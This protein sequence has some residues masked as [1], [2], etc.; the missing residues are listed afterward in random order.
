MAILDMPNQVGWMWWLPGALAL[1]QYKAARLAHDFVAVAFHDFGT[2]VHEQLSCVQT[3]ELHLRSADR[4][5][6][7]WH[8]RC[9]AGFGQ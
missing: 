4:D 9:D 6:Q 2:V 1:R 3:A 7:S 8:L 5:R